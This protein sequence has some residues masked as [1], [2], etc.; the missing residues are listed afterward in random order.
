MS[1]E[2][3]GVHVV[4]TIIETIGPHLDFSYK[5]V[6][7]TSDVL[8]DVIQ[9]SV[10]R[11]Q[12]HRDQKGLP[13]PEVLY[14]QLDNTNSNKSKALFTYLSWLVETGVFRKIKVNYLLVGHTHE[15]IDQVFSRYSVALRKVNCLT[16]QELME[17]AK[18][19]YNP[20]PT[21]AHVQSVTGWWKWFKLANAACLTTADL[22]FN[23]A[24]RIKRRAPDPDQDE[25]G[26]P[27]PVV[28]HSKTLGWREDDSQPKSWAPRGG[29][30]QL[31]EV[32]LGEPTFLPLRP[33]EDNDFTSLE[34]I[35]NGFRNNFGEAFSGDLKAYWE[36]E[37]QFQNAVRDGHDTPVGYE[38]LKVSPY[39]SQI[40]KLMLLLQPPITRNSSWNDFFLIQTNLT[41]MFFFCRYRSQPTDPAREPCPS[42]WLDRYGRAKFGCLTRG[43]ARESDATQSTHYRAA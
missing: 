19:C 39:R 30:R 21:V 15:I 2:E 16:L 35:V 1:K 5:N 22:S 4:G 3:Y 6:G 12:D 11:L 33:L 29:V 32:P 36:A 24:F 10:K 37:L 20:N 31:L 7:D 42:N 38:L 43:I 23:H 9:S 18:T 25:A 13:Y 27:P 8:I 26:T 34:R 17:V 41:L 14:L 28:M 40:G